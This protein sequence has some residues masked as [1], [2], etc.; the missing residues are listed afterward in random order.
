MVAE[1]RRR[2]MDG[3]VQTISYSLPPGA[4]MESL[5]LDVPAD[6]S[7]VDLWNGETWIDARVG[8]AGPGSVLVSVPASAVDGGSVYIRALVDGP[9][10]APSI[11]SAT[12]D[13]LAEAIIPLVAAGGSEEG[14]A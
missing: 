7:A 14:G 9:F 11:R 1:Q 13:E 4:D 12:A 3:D 2:Q 10:S 5:V 6:V 8:S